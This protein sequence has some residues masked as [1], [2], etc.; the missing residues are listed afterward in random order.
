M[1][2]QGSYAY[3]LVIPVTSQL[4]ILQN[5]FMIKPAYVLCTLHVLYMT[6]YI[7]SYLVPPDIF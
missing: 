4:S 5:L 2:V 3:K 6:V 7:C 1:F